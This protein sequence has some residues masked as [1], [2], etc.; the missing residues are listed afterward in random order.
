MPK[1]SP[2]SHS[3]YFQRYIDQVPEND[4][5]EA[6]RNQLPVISSFFE[7]ISEEKSLYA[8]APGKWTLRE[9]LQHM[10]DTER[11]FNY[12]ALCFARKEAASLPGFEE[13][14]YAAHSNANQRSWQS[15]AE[16]FAA[17]RRATEL[18]FESFTAE[19]LA[20]SGISNNNPCSVA[21]VGFI[22]I[23]HFYH[24][25]KVVEERYL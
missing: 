20:S 12:R 6:F 17:V 8:Y 16:E 9:L 24:H 4:L 2:A 10:I 11:I 1:P 22:M 13:D 21:S 19:A 5:R 3:V 25:K 15:L 23:G 18:L 14:D 7:G